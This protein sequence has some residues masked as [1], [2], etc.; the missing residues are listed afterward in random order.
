MV[1]NEAFYNLN[2]KMVH[3]QGFIWKEGGRLWGPSYPKKSESL[4]SNIFQEVSYIAMQR[5][6]VRPMVENEAFDNKFYD[7]KWKWTIF[8]GI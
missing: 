8:E 3:F 7:K 1:E 6:S 5:F 4:P 2:I